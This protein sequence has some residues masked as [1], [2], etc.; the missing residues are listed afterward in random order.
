MEINCNFNDLSLCDIL[1]KKITNLS[2]F[3]SFAFKSSFGATL[4][5]AFS[6]KD[7]ILHTSYSLS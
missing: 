2:F 3:V 1:K 7:N 5:Y 6:N 4:L